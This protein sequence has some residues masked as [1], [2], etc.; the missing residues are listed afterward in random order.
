MDSFFEIYFR[1]NL[2]NKS[3]KTESFL[4]VIVFLLLLVNTIIVLQKPLWLD[5]VIT[6]ICSKENTLINLIINF[7]NGIDTN[8]P[9]YF[10]LI[11][12]SIKIS[13]ENIFVLRFLSLILTLIGLIYFLKTIK[14]FGHEKYLSLLL[15]MNS[16]FITGYLFSEIRPYS[17]FF[18]LGAI[19]IYLF[20]NIMINKKYSFIDI[21]KV[22]VFL[23]IFL[24]THYFS[25]FYFIGLIVWCLIS[26]EEL[27]FKY[28]LLFFLIPLILFLPWIIGIKNQ[29]E[30]VKGFFWQE[31]ATIFR[32]I[33]LPYYFLG[34]FAIVLLVIIIINLFFYK[35]YISELISQISLNVKILSLAIVFV[36]IPVVVSILSMFKLLP[37]QERYLLISIFGIVIIFNTL[38][39]KRKDYKKIFYLL[40]IIFISINIYKNYSSQ[41]F[42]EKDLK[43]KLDL[44]KYKVPIVC[45]S[46]HVYF[47]L[48]YYSKKYSDKF[49]LLLDLESAKL[50]GNIKNSLFDYYW[51][52]NLKK[53]RDSLNIS[54][55]STFINNNSEFILINEEG[56]L[57]FE[58]NIQ[59]NKN[60]LIKE[61]G[62]NI[63]FIKNTKK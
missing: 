52:K 6:I 22:N 33:K 7:F 53:Y 19:I 34:Y 4:F 18:C 36:L 61:I 3:L 38:F 63:L 31:P 5:E 20:Y 25:I 26:L 62:N 55:F 60:Y 10:L 24:Y 46:P 37:Y 58:Y 51:I 57:L 41:L 11:N 8:P 2:K 39:H 48:H 23:T 30:A 9:F 17:L 43:E 40:S 15:I 44:T 16:N 12:L 47:P 32:L 28:L 27:K 54:E 21:I 49:Y 56:R 35:K 1:K 29:F 59:N 50:K 14:C 45:E 13:N 42:M